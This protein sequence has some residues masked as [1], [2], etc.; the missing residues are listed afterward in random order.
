MNSLLDTSPE[1]NVANDDSLI[2]E[3]VKQSQV[4]TKI[5]KPLFLHTPVHYFAKTRITNRHKLTV[6]IS[7]PLWHEQYI[8]CKYYLA[9]FHIFYCKDHDYQYSN[10]YLLNYSDLDAVAKKI[11]LHAKEYDLWNTIVLPKKEHDGY[12]FYHFSAS[13]KTGNVNKFYLENL[14]LLRT[15][16]LYYD[17]KISNYYRNNKPF[18]IFINKLLTDPEL[19]IKY[20]AEANQT[21]NNVFSEIEKINRYYLP[22]GNYLTSCEVKCLKLC[23]LGKTAPEIAEELKKSQRTIEKHLEQAKKKAD[24]PKL[25]CLLTYLLRIGIIS[26]REI[27][28]D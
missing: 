25:T 16:I 22:N 20:E 15:F 2:N 10:Y 11:M 27:Y 4:I 7:N 17:D 8:N 5:C 3:I 23:F 1:L 26:M 9:D 6:E 14:D 13:P 12:S 24:I 28:N 21:Y 18:K 19:S